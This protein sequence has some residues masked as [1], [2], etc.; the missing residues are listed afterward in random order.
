MSMN[1]FRCRFCGITQ[2]KV[3]IS[4]EEMARLLSCCPGC[5]ADHFAEGYAVV[6]EDYDAEVSTPHDFCEGDAV[7]GYDGD[8]EYRGV[9]HAVYDDVVEIE[10]LDEFGMDV[11]DFHVDDVV[12][13]L[14]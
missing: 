11:R 9:I 13:A 5:G 10:Y 7:V 4:D 2:A 6:N 1:F 8:V 3:Y 12:E 14:S